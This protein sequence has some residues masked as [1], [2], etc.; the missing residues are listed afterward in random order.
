M[1]N[2][3]H[4]IVDGPQ[5]AAC[6]YCDKPLTGASIRF[7]TYDLHEHCY[8]QLGSELAEAR[9][10]NQREER[11]VVHVHVVKVPSE[12]GAFPILVQGEKIG[13]TVSA[14]GPDQRRA[15]AL[16]LGVTEANVRYEDEVFDG[17]YNEVDVWRVKPAIAV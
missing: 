12:A 8:L 5:V 9:E 6:P 11:E 3:T 14:A 10:A 2:L 1:N 4:L 15:I 13:E 16:L 17:D 7:G